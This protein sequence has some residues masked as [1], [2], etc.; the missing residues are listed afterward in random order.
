M[1]EFVLC[2]KSFRTVKELDLEVSKII[3][4]KDN[5]IFSNIFFLSKIHIQKH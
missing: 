2:K 1:E 4:E 3:T 5:N